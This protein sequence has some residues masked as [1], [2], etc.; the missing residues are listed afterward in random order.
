MKFYTLFLIFTL[1]TSNSLYAAYCD[2]YDM[3]DIFERGVWRLDLTENNDSGS[4]GRKYEFMFTTKERNKN[5]ATLSKF[6]K[7]P[8]VNSS[9][10]RKTY[11]ARKVQL[12]GGNTDVTPLSIERFIIKQGNATNK[13][14]PI[15]DYYSQRDFCPYTISIDA[16]QQYDEQD[17]YEYN[18][19]FRLF[20]YADERQ[21]D[22]SRYEFDIDSTSYMFEYNDEENEM[23]KMIVGTLKL[24]EYY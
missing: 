24:I 11:W 23:D 15:D 14:I 16:K 9:T 8:K 17:S 19:K 1:G 7:F 2:D 10:K 6:Y 12:N 20:I 3:V 4:N 18:A 22:S 5:T 13:L 21:Q